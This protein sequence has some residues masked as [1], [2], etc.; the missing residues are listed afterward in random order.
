MPS[1]HPQ[2]RPTRRPGGPQR[3]TPATSGSARA[4]AEAAPPRRRF[5]HRMAV[6]VLVVGVLVV[7]YASSMRAYLDQRSHLADLRAQIAS[8][9]QDIESLEREQRR[10]DDEAFLEAQARERFGWVMPGETSYQVI[11]RD[12]EPLVATDDLPDPGSV[13][14]E[15]P[16]AWWSKV[17]GTV[18]TADHPERVRTPATQLEA[19]SND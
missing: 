11:G 18:E 1:R 15:L 2:Q 10:W 13:P 6:L 3:R 19:P 17:W 5:T 8:T 12:G 9:E 14:E 16:E 4:T 7:S